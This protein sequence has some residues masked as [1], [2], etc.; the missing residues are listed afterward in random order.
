MIMGQ[1]MPN[2]S[3]ALL[4]VANFR[5]NTGYAWDFIERLYA[6]IA[7]HLALH[8][9]RTL[10]AY[11]EITTPPRTLLGSAAHAVALDG[12]L[13]TLESIRA[14]EQMIRRES[15][16]VVYFTDRPAWCSRYLGL[17]RAGVRRIIVHDH[18]SGERT[19]PRGLKW[20]AKYMLARIPG[21]S[22]DVVVAVSNY[23][24]RRQVE[25]GLIPL[26]RVVTVWNGLAVVE[27][28][29]NTDCQARKIFSLT[30]QRPLIVCAARATPEKG[31]AHLLQAFDRVVKAEPCR[32]QRPILIYIGDGPQLME[33][34]SLRDDLS[35]KDDI[36]VA[37]YR[38][39]ASEIVKGADIC[40]VPSVWQDAFPLAV[41]EA[42]AGGK[43]IIATR[44]GGI[45]ELIEHGVS[46]LLVPPAD[47]V[48]LAQAIQSLLAD[49][50]RAARLG[51]AAIQRVAERFTLERQLNHLI[52]LVEE[53]FDGPC[54]AVRD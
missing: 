3:A 38:P 53:G 7:D 39:D 15:V 21:I 30:S 5:A 44:V 28:H 16:Q 27:K 36:I 25:I 9:I 35:A 23:V 33:L 13:D 14:M 40:V 45:P 32:T 48:A 31:V 11:P 52:A 1:M 22:A 8:G 34:Q 50:S 26:E 12:S 49:P 51:E 46:G 43:P 6:G 10:V 2:T 19:R 41:L 20:A 18:S 4:C 24:A 42:M 54:K 37:G 29:R 17:R 47:E